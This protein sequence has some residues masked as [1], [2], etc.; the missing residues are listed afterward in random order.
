MSQNTF[1]VS[2]RG[3]APPIFAEFGKKAYVVTKGHGRYDEY[4]AFKEKCPCCGDAGTIIYNGFELKCSYCEKH[5]SYISIK[6]WVVEEYIV[7]G[8]QLAGPDRKKAYGNMR[9]ESD[10]P[11]VTK[12]Q[13]FCRSGNGYDNVKTR[14]IPARDNDVDRPLEK[15]LRLPSCVETVAFTTRAL[16]EEVCEAMKNIER[17]KLAAFNEAHGTHHEFP[18]G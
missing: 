6:N 13:G 1:S 10:L 9:L 3:E 11:Q 14:D 16:A 5:R 12:I 7:N 15:I 17:E 8:I 4:T 18:Y 2:L